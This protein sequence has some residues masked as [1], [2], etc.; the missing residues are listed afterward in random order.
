MGME[1]IHGVDGLATQLAPKLTPPLVNPP[2]LNMVYV[3]IATSG[4]LLGNWS[5]SQP[6]P[7]VVERIRR[8]IP[9]SPPARQG[10]S[11]PYPEN[12][13]S[14]MRLS[15][16]TILLIISRN[17]GYG[18][19]RPDT[20]LYIFECTYQLYSYRDIIHGEISQ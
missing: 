7:G 5:V 15:M 10:L 14:V 9:A 3:A 1:H 11:R 6:F 19:A 18:N 8:R 20:L 16:P 13:M 2:A 17:T 4:R 12:A